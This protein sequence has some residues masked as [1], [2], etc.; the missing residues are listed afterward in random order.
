MLGLAM[1]AALFLLTTAVLAER[2]F[3]RSLRPG[4]SPHAPTLVWRPG[5]E[6]W[7]EPTGTPRERSEDWET[8]TLTPAQ[9]ANEGSQAGEAALPSAG[10]QSRINQRLLC[11]L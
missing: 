8:E 9:S 10:A 11:G 1:L 4:P 6:L 7:I 3:R 5:G 2:L